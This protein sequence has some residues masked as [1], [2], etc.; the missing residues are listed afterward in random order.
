ME[1]PSS[2]RWGAASGVDSGTSG[3]FYMDEFV[4]RDE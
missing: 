1:K 2:I 3:T 4:L